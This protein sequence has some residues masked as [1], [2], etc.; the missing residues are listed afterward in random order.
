MTHLRRLIRAPG[1]YF[2]TSS[3]WQRR[4]VFA[5][6]PLARLFLDCLFH[7]RDAGHYLLH[8]FVLMPDH[9]HILLTPAPGVTLERALQY[10][11]G[12]SSHA[13]RK[14]LLYRFP[15]WQTGFDDHRIRNAQDYDSH[16]EYIL[17]NPSEAKLAQDSNSYLYCSARAEFQPML[18]RWPPAASAAKA[19]DKS[20]QLVRPG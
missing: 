4:P 14:T 3:T 16:R 1:T 18:D 20:A 17:N 19:E 11:K 6:E 12:G 5:K 15:I 13:I 10:V 9:F 2:V 8:E 7:Y